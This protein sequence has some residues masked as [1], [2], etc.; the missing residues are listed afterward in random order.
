MSLLVATLLAFDSVFLQTLLCFFD[1]FS[2]AGKEAVYKGVFDFGVGASHTV[3]NFVVGSRN[4]ILGGLI[5]ANNFV[6]DVLCS[7]SDFRLRQDGL[8]R[9]DS[10]GIRAVRVGNALN[11]VAYAIR[12]CR[13]V[14]R[15]RLAPPPRRTPPKPASAA[16]TTATMQ[17]MLRI[18]LSNERVL[19]C[20][21]R[22]P[23]EEACQ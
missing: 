2:F 13:N 17:V 21:T 9:F 5:C 8:L 6:G 12:K 14:G 22:L 16:P 7:L 1:V 4:G 18:R 23:S 3:L 20:P 10:F 19:G 15:A 11:L